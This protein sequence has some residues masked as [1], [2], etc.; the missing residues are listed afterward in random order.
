M[1][2]LLSIAA[3]AMLIISGLAPARSGAAEQGA[4]AYVRSD[5]GVSNTIRL[6]QPD[7]TGD[8]AILTLPD[9]GV[10]NVPQ[11]AWSPDASELAFA[12]DHE[13]TTSLYSS[14]IYAVRP[15][16]S[17]LRRLTNGPD[18]RQ[19]GAYP[20]GTVTVDVQ[21]PADGGPYLVYVAGAPA[22]QAAPAGGLR[23]LTFTSVADLG[24]GKVQFVVAMFGAS[25]W[26]SAGSGADVL[27]GQ[28]VSAGT[29]ILSGQGLQYKAF[30]PTWRADGGAVGFAFGSGAR[31]EQV[32]ASPPAGAL[33]SDIIAGS[34]IPG[35]PGLVEYA[36]LTSLA[37]QILYDSFD[38]NGESIYRA[39]AGATSPGSPLVTFEHTVIDLKWLPDGSGFLAA[40]P[41]WDETSS[42]IYE[43]QFASGQLTQVT[44][45]SGEVAGH[46]SISPD[47]RT[48]VFERA[49][50]LSAPA[51]LWLIGRDGSNLRLLASDAARPAWSSRPPQAPE[52]HGVYL[53]AVRR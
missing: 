9:S 13:A 3:L 27:A 37:N 28:T 12:S 41:T 11:L 24:P 44:H 6:I 25:R 53:P 20:T 47:G 51:S 39:S 8:R 42:N 36:P 34:A 48:I 23:R 18:R 35:F 40:V 43:Y 31:P 7:G 2:R 1:P 49:A 14:D 16:G 33:G 38:F 46:L 30:H 5:S 15:D 19:L 50:S 32:P 52:L 4:I 21:T 45:F 29:L 26:L 22:P 17:G 10:G